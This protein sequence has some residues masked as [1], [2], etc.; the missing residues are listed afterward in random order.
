MNDLL[1][2]WSI[3]VID[4]SDQSFL[5]LLISFGN[6]EHNWVSLPGGSTEWIPCLLYL[7]NL[8]RF[9]NEIDIHIVSIL[10]VK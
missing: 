10:N 2:A 4:V 6:L 7:F 9:K 8:V 1:Q 3:F 5:V